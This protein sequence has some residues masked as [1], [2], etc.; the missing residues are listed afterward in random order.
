MCSRA[1][2]RSGL[3]PDLSVWEFVLV[4]LPPNRLQVQGAGG[5]VLWRGI[6]ESLRSS[7]DA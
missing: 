3:D 1:T 6:A 2:T 4:V 7:Y 5:S